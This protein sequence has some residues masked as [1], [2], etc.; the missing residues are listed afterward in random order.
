MLQDSSEHYRKE[1][2]YENQELLSK[3]S[4]SER[5]TLLKLC[6]WF[7]KLTKIQSTNTLFYE[8]IETSPTYTIHNIQFE[9]ITRSCTEYQLESLSIFRRNNANDAALH[10]T[11][12]RIPSVALHTLIFK[13][14]PAPQNSEQE[15]KVETYKI[16]LRLLTRRTKNITLDTK[17]RMT[18]KLN[19]NAGWI[20][21][22]SSTTNSINSLLQ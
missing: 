15:T 16:E 9:K 4:T 2:R 21:I 18:E 20:T 13:R 12:L 5:N 1:D 11:D 7:V 22:K 17:S 3:N 6:V 19:A 8:Q 10:A 14:I